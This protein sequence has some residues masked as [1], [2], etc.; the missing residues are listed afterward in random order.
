MHPLDG[1]RVCDITTMINGPYASMLLS[2]MGADVIK[3]EPPDGDP[4]R[5]VAGGFLAFNRGKRSIVLDLK[6]PE[7]RQ[8]AYKLI[9]TSDILIENAR[10]GVWHRLGLDYDSLKKIKPDIIYLSVLGHGS[11]GPF[12]ALPGYDPLLQA[13]SGQ[14]VAQGG[15]GKPPVFHRIPIN[16]IACPILGAYG[17]VLALIVRARTGRGQNVETSLTNAS[18]T[19]QPGDFLD[20][21]GLKRKYFGDTGI[22]GLSA[23]HRLYQAGDDRWILIFCPR[24]KNWR[25]LCQAMELE[26]LLAD[27]R[28]ETPEKRAENDGALV[29]LL[30]HAFRGKSSAHWLAALP[31]SDVPTA[32]AQSTEELMNDR[33]CLEN[34]LIDER[35][36]PELGRVR[37]YG[38]AFQFSD[39]CGI[40]RNTAPLLGQHTEEVLTE[41][42]HTGEQIAEL[43]ADRIVFMTKQ[44]K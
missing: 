28:F 7:A 44:S 25:S 6:K 11:K 35:E 29:E 30:G 34:N 15:V 19:M 3:I 18:I 4:W 8:I 12:S 1:I 23:T 31:Q 24:E 40:I 37:Q 20:Y 14:M 17:A 32:L 27:P 26:A 9:A 38:L 39:M 2:D 16:D 21:K 10:W 13:R 43:A 41:L 42:G 33:H 5:N 22:K 36:H